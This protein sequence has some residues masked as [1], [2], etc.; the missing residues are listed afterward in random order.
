MDIVAAVAIGIIAIVLTQ[1]GVGGLS[2]PVAIALLFFVPGHTV[3]GLLVAPSNSSFSGRSRAAGLDNLDR[4]IISIA[5][6]LALGA[7]GGVLLNLT[8]WGLTAT[9]WEVYFTAI[10]IIAGVPVLLRR[11]AIRLSPAPAAAARRLPFSLQEGIL[12]GFAVILVLAA[13]GIARVGAQQQYFPGFTQLWI[14]HLGTNDVRLAVRN[15]DH[16]INEYSLRVALDRR[17]VTIWHLIV[18]KPGQ[19]WARDLALPGPRTKSAHLKAT[20]N[21]YGSSQSPY[22]Y[23]NV[24]VPPIKHVFLIVMG[25][26]AWSN[27]LHSPRAPYINHKLLPLASYADRY[28]DLSGIRASLPN[29]L[30]LVSGS[31]FGIVRNISPSAHPLA[32]G[33]HLDRLLS[34]F[35]VSWS[36]YAEGTMTSTCPLKNRGGYVTAHDP[37]VY[38]SD[39]TKNRR[40]CASHVQ[41]LSALAPALKSNRV[42]SFSYIA[43]DNCDD[44]S[45]ACR[46]S[47]QRVRQGDE[48]LSDE[49][50]GIRSSSAYKHDGAIFIV[51]DGASNRGTT[52][53]TGPAG[54]IVLSPL[55]KGHGYHDRVRYT[56]SSVLRT[57]QELLDVR[58][59][60][61]QAGHAPDLRGLFSRLS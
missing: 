14:R 9:S 33:G 57:I 28:Y 5:L 21:L 32:S 56:G 2:I 11:R 40:Y 15:R 58:P 22:R 48:W 35:H 41:P 12:F 37:F 50:P 49:I 19:K 17:Q 55:G 20:L 43:P 13:V 52:P 26:E 44:M 18:L 4:V 34:K 61:G 30:W 46:P 59:Y 8:P 3:M 38:F 24:L 31:N 45:T 27:I 23:V 47:N 53:S 51:W 16:H 1:L 54:L 10:T 36:S 25:N 6:S 39:V 29:N 42:P 60:L 7:L